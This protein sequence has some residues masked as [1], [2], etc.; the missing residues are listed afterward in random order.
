M[1]VSFSAFLRREPSKLGAVPIAIEPMPDLVERIR[2]N[3]KINGVKFEVMEA[4]ASNENGTARLGYN[5]KVRFT[6]GASL[7]RK[8]GG[9]HIVRTVRLDTIRGLDKLAAI[10][11][12]VERAEEQVLKGA[13]KLIAREQPIL[14]IETLTPEARQVVES[15]LPKYRVLD[16]LD[17][18]NLILEPL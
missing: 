17:N 7:H 14:F 6:S 18:R 1:I 10:K 11:I 15:M 13:L 5:D 4:A 3:S 8:S 16:F 12:D 9:S 2:E